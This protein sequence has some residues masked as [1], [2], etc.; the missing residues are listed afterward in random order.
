MVLDIIIVGLAIISGFL[1]VKKG[2]VA[3]ITKIIGFVLATVFA[4]MFYRQLANYINSNYEFPAKI[5]NSIKKTITSESDS[6]KEDVYI[7]LS[8]IINKFHLSDKIDLN[9]EQKNITEEMDLSDIVSNKI[10]SYVI[11]IIAFLIIFLG[12]IIVTSVLSLILAAVFS[13]PLLST[14][15]RLGG[16]FVEIVLFVI[17]LCIVLEIISVL[18][19]LGF[20]SWVITQ[21]DNSVFVKFLYYNNYLASLVYRIK[22]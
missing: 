21:I 12:V 16:F 14:I 9:E 6:S 10:T 17:K 4:F 11:N 1:G 15:N 2:M 13:L 19:P 7:S 18:S 8:K 20:M 5:N 3:I 22:L